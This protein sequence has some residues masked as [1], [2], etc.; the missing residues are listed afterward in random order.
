MQKTQKTLPQPQQIL[1]NKYCVLPLFMWL[2]SAECIPWCIHSVQQVIALIPSMVLATCSG[3]YYVCI[4]AKMTD[5]LSLIIASQPKSIGINTSVIVQTRL[6][7][8]TRISNGE[9]IERRSLS[10]KYFFPGFYTL[11]RLLHG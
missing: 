11:S 6:A 1:S 2:W 4:Q 10:G 8:H 7:D 3:A 5:C 9:C